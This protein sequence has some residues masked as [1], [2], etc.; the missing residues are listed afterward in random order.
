M[1]Y[2]IL[3]NIYEE[4]GLSALPMATLYDYIATDVVKNSEL[5]IKAKILKSICLTE[6]GYIS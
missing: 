6:A 5:S 3:R 2:F 1:E 4:N